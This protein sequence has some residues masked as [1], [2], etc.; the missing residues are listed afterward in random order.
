MVSPKNVTTPKAKP[1][2]KSEK[3]HV[4]ISICHCPHGHGVR[5]WKMKNPKVIG[6]YGSKEE[7]EKR[8]NQIIAENGG[9]CGHGHV[10]VG[11]S[12]EDEID[13]FI[14]PFDECTL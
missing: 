4:I 6:V 12:W 13:L 1:K 3:P 9:R 11:G 5:G 10:V 7:A 8:K 14:R 2:K